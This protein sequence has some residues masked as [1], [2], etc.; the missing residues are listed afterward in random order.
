MRVLDDRE[1][2]RQHPGSAAS[3]Q[4]GGT[5]DLFL[6]NTLFVINGSGRRRTSFTIDGSTG[7]DA[8]GRQTIFTNIP[9][10]AI[11]EFTVLTNGF[12]AEYGRTTGSVIR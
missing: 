9:P 12:S 10:S 2:T 11:Q 6:N 3:E 1:L 5:G 8:W 4:S 7:D